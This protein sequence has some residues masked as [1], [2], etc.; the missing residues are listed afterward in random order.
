MCV[1]QCVGDASFQTHY[2]YCCFCTVLGGTCLKLPFISV[3]HYREENKHWV[4]LFSF[5]LPC[6]ELNYCWDNLDKPLQSNEKVSYPN[7]WFIGCSVLVQW[8][9]AISSF[10]K[11]TADQV[12]FQPSQRCAQASIVGARAWNSYFPIFS[13][14]LFFYPNLRPTSAI[15]LDTTKDPPF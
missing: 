9:S 14:D 6:F 12:I 15:V 1:G 7:S 11:W 10:P 4:P 3:V 5:F 2:W 13:T 8:W